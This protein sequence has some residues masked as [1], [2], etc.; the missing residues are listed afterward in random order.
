MSL[1]SPRVWI[2]RAQPGAARTAA[3]LTALGFEPVVAPLLAIRRVAL[4]LE[5]RPVELRLSRCHT[6]AHTYHIQ[7]R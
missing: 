7:L 6:A 1:T 2:T 4:D 3:R 5:D